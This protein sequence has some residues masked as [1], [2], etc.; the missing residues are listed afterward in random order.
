M[1]LELEP[2]VISSACKIGCRVRDFYFGLDYE[3]I[4]PKIL[5]KTIRIGDV[6]S[7]VNGVSVLS[8]SFMDILDILTSN[9]EAPQRVLQFK[10]VSVASVSR[11]VT[12]EL[13]NMNE[14]EKLLTSNRLDDVPPHDVNEINADNNLKMT[15]V[16]SVH[17]TNNQIDAPSSSPAAWKT[18]PATPDIFATSS[19]TTTPSVKQTSLPDEA[20]SL[21]ISP[22]AVRA[23]SRARALVSP[24]GQVG[25]AAL[26]QKDISP[27]DLGQ[28]IGRVGASIGH[29]FKGVAHKILEP[30]DTFAHQK[31]AEAAIAR[32]HELLAELS[33]SCVL[34]GQAEEKESDLQ[35]R[36]DF[37]LEEESKHKES[38][39]EA[40]KKVEVLTTRV[41]ELEASS[42]AQDEIRE[43]LQPHLPPISC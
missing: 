34:L 33:R 22:K 30:F 15:P 14:E 1:G 27:V 19:A 18:Y 42:H 38:L 5:Q 21:T 3:G 41:A 16:K 9:R 35:T 13:Q 32:K 31:Q 2:V 11:S 23:L 25:T 36:L 20:F 40:E 26:L 43:R 10:N 17:A 39:V 37:A 4:D 12:V 29:S 7:S 6:I 28:A 24:D 8:S